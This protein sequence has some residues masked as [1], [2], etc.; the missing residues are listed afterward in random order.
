[1][2]AQVH[3]QLLKLTGAPAC[4]CLILPPPP[5]LTSPRLASSPRQA[6]TVDGFEVA[7]E[8]SGDRLAVDVPHI[9][10]LHAGKQEQ[11]L[12]ITY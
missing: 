9:G 1:M 3:K 10:S 4:P 11:Q 12:V 7:F 5:W 8:H 2:S 6:C